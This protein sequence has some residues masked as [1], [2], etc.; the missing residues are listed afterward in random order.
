MSVSP[1]AAGP[2]VL[3][4]TVVSPD[5]PPTVNPLIE[6]LA[7]LMDQ[8]ITVPGLNRRIGLDGLLGLI[9]VVGDAATALVG[10][11]FLAEAQRVGV[12]K[13]GQVRMAGNYLI[14]LAIGAIPL[15]G[16]LFDFGFKANTRNL[17]IIRNHV[18]RRRRRGV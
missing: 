9:P 8:S 4:G 17:R 11:A 7:H 16:D 6:R 13:W 5:G 3:T 18:E 12:S 2:R 1:P 10:L 14:D 15:V